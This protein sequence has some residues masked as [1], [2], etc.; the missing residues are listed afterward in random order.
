MM[1]AKIFFPIFVFQVFLCTSTVCEC[2]KQARSQDRIWGGA[3]P[4]KVDFLNL[5]PLNPPTKT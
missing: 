4:L 1:N 2:C 3:E 5:T